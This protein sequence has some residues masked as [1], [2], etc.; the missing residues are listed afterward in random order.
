MKST[1]ISLHRGKYYAKYYGVFWLRGGGRVDEIA[2]EEKNEYYGAG[3]N[4]KQGKKK[5][6]ERVNLNK[7]LCKLHKKYLYIVPL[8]VIL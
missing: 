5:K 6:G 7:K 2:A 8:I 4:I 3:K 1:Y